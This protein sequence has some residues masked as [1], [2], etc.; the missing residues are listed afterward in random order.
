MSLDVFHE[1]IRLFGVLHSG[2]RDAMISCDWGRQTAS[3]LLL[4]DVDVQFRTYPGVGHEI[5]PSE[6]LC[7]VYA[8]FCMS[9][10]TSVLFVHIA[11]SCQTSLG[12]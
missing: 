12:G 6:V 10:P 5:D 1:C 3:N 11:C 7:I 8:V 2:E 4:R 9:E